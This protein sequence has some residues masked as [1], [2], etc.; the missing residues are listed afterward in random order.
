MKKI[1][2]FLGLLLS[3]GV[4]GQQSI[5]INST[6]RVAAAAPAGGGDDNM[7]T[8]GTFDDAAGWTLS[9]AAWVISGGVA[10]YDDTGNSKLEQ[11]DADMAVSIQPNTAY[12]LTLDISGTSGGGIYFSLRS[13]ID[14]SSDV[15]YKA[16]AE[17]TNGTGQTIQFTTPAD[18]VDGG[19]SIGGLSAGDSGG[20]LDNLILTAD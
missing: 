4:L 12:T 19:L 14:G 15:L 8:N 10:T 2:V 13:V 17:Y 5:M 1:L 9:S 16:A 18:I 7:L 3:I 6:H 11:F 20:V